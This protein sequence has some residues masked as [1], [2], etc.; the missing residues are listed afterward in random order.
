VEMAMAAVAAVYQAAVWLARA[1]A[2]DMAMAAAG[3]VEGAVKG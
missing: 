2:V 3:E 1:G